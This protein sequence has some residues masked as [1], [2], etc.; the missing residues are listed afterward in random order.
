MRQAEVTAR[1]GDL[2]Q[3]PGSTTAYQDLGAYPALYEALH[4]D[5]SRSAFADLVDAYLGVAVRYERTYGLPILDT[6]A[7]FFAQHGNVAATARALGLNRQSLLYRLER[8]ETLSGVDLDSPSERFALEL[9]LRCWPI[10]QARPA[11]AV[12]ATWERVHAEAT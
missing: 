11:S 9:A 8:F 6:L 7:Q 12:D 4:A 1:I 10:R 2:L 5:G 3:G